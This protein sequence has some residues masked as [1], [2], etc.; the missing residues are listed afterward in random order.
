[1]ACSRSL[2]ASD[3]RDGS[4][5]PTW[6]LPY[7]VT[8]TEISLPAGRGILAAPRA[9]LA[10][11]RL[12]KWRKFLK[13]RGPSGDDDHRIG[14]ADG[15]SFDW[16]S[17]TDSF[18]PADI[19]LLQRRRPKRTGRGCGAQSWSSRDSLAD[20]KYDCGD[21]RSPRQQQPLMWSKIRRPCGE[22][23]Q[24]GRAP[25]GETP[26]AATDWAPTKGPHEGNALVVRQRDT[27][28]GR[29]V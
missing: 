19:L 2:S 7:G 26:M 25:V 23:R 1:M 4:P 5:G 15:R 16:I 22:L 18:L 28:F 12:P 10:A 20:G 17:I 6:R 24:N 29:G 27:G 21:C 11:A 9:R 14:A 8:E 13:A 3:F